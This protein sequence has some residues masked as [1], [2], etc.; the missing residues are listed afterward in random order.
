[1]N[2]SDHS[3]HFEPSLVTIVGAFETFS[4]NSA[5][6]ERNIFPLGGGSCSD[7]IIPMHWT[8]GVLG[9]KCQIGCHA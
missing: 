8:W 5:S 9:Y 4:I 1:M 2:L 6:F 3:S 7:L